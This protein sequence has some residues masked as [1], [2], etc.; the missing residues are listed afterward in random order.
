[1]KPLIIIVPGSLP[2]YPPGFKQ[3]FRKLYE[4]F[5]ADVS[6]N[7]W[8]YNLKKFFESK[9]FNVTVFK[10]NCGFTQTFSVNPAAK[11]LAVLINKHRGKVILFGKSIGGVVAETATHYV[12]NPDKISKLIYV[13]S[14]HRHK[15]AK[16]PDSIPL[17]NIFS[18]DDKMEVIANKLLYVG[19]GR[20]SLTNAKNISLTGLTHSNFNHN[21]KFTYN[22]KK[23]K[24]FDFYTRFLTV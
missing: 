15:K 18:I 23:L 20:K 3:N 2:K 8:T 22:G 1:M 21:T 12:S 14:P 17:I 4:Y 16:V 5:G 13:A 10:W 19:N 6:G 24:M 7:E 11:Q 9:K